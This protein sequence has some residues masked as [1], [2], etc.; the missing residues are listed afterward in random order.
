MLPELVALLVFILNLI[1]NRPPHPH[2]PTFLGMWEDG[3]FRALAFGVIED[4]LAEAECFRRD[5][6]VLIL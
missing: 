1:L 4:L 3:L 6:E 2:P 5:L